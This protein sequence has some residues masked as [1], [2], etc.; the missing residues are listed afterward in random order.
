MSSRITV[1]NT[2]LTNL[3]YAGV[4]TTGALN[5]TIQYNLVDGITGS[6]V[7][8]WNG[9]GIAI[10]YIS[11]SGNSKDVVVENN[12]VKNIPTWHG[13]DT[14]SGVRIIFRNNIVSGV[15]RAVFLT[16]S[17]TDV[18]ADSND[19][20]APTAAQIAACPVG[21]PITYCQ[22]IRGISVSGGT[23]IISNNVGH[24]WPASRWLNPISGSSGYST[25]NN[26][27]PIP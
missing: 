14:H 24:N 9:Y 1:K 2:V 17:P 18:L 12:T 4:L 3:T 8:E 23:G 20:T 10:S 11:G 15:R 27:P 19:L 6:S 13:L 16:G 26:N 22:D 5:S 21:A 25:P 7:D